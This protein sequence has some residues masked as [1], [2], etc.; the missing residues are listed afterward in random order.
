VCVLRDRFSGRPGQSV[1]LSLDGGPL[2]FF[3]AETGQAIADR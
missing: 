3:D 1:A 2:H